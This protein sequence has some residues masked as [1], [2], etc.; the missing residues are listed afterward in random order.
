[1]L[2]HLTTFLG[3]TAKPDASE[4]AKPKGEG[5]DFAAV[6]EN[7]ADQMPDKKEKFVA[8]P[9]EAGAPENDAKDSPLSNTPVEPG[10]RKAALDKA[11]GRSDAVAA[12]DERVETGSFDDASDE[13]GLTAD[14]DAADTGQEFT[15]ATPSADRIAPRRK[16]SASDRN[17]SFETVE[18]G[19]AQR[20]KEAFMPL[21]GS[22]GP[23]V[24]NEHPAHAEILKAGDRRSIESDRNLTSAD[25][26]SMDVAG[27]GDRTR[28]VLPPE[29]A[30]DA[31]LKRTDFDSRGLERSTLDNRGTLASRDQENGI[32]QSGATADSLAKA[33]AQ[34]VGSG[35]TGSGRAD[36]GGAM[37]GRRADV[38]NG[39]VQTDAMMAARLA[40]AKGTRPT[41]NQTFVTTR[42]TELASASNTARPQDA[43][44]KVVRNGEPKFTTEPGPSDPYSWTRALAARRA[45]GG[46][47]AET[48]ARM[49]PAGSVDQKRARSSGVFASGTTNAIQTSIESRRDQM[50]PG[51]VGRG[52][53]GINR[54]V[55]S[56]MDASDVAQAQA[57]LS[58]G[59]PQ[60]KFGHSLL[61]THASSI[62]EAREGA[63]LSDQV[64][65][66]RGNA[67]ADSFAMSKL[68]RAENSIAID[69]R[70][71]GG[72]MEPGLRDQAAR[73]TQGSHSRGEIEMVPSGGQD[74]DP[75][76]S[77]F[78][79][80]RGDKSDWIGQPN[81]PSI[82]GE[83]N[84]KLDASVTTAARERNR[85]GFSAPNTNEN[86]T[87][88]PESRS[89][90]QAVL[91]SNLRNG[92]VGSPRASLATEA[93]VD[94]V[95][96]S[97]VAFDV[98]SKPNSQ[99]VGPGAA[100]ADTARHL[101]ASP[102][103]SVQ[104]FTQQP[105]FRNPAPGDASQQGGAP[106]IDETPIPNRFSAKAIASGQLSVNQNFERNQARGDV[107][108]QERTALTEE[109][110][111]SERATTEPV[112]PPRTMSVAAAPNVGPAETPRPSLFDQGRVRSQEEE[113][114]VSMMRAT[115]ELRTGT[116]LPLQT[117]S[118]SAQTPHAPTMVLR[119]IM[120]QIPRLSEGKIE[121]RLSPEELG[122]VRMHMTPG[123]QGMTVHIQADRPETLDLLRRNIDQLARDLAEAG[124]ETANFSFGEGTGQN[125]ANNGAE[126]RGREGPVGT[127]TDTAIP[128]AEIQQSLTASMDGL[129][130]RV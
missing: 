113:L 92:A 14:L 112:A 24:E 81:R 3:L 67:S 127:S 128:A 79:P 94:M 110:R 74:S 86:E 100:A 58:E 76:T 77:N 75:K 11:L 59:R 66:G 60:I 126:E 97:S 114:D 49:P 4:T 68:A 25:G 38:Q 65:S 36:E 34:T 96:R 84:S 22:D 53:G 91:Q 48:T 95:G 71:N 32:G 73:G 122:H 45:D 2:T 27:R 78:E 54:G 28:S 17:G 87:L 125:D 72:S 85:E 51:E 15:L 39:Q 109:R 107:L 99:A 33:G 35:A 61:S 13:Y 98:S 37:I 102:A 120:D 10:S 129:D 83:A 118:Q 12:G 88:R 101:A 50:L 21:P 116:T 23:L 105:P 1:M 90:P 57:A 111:G 20:E 69:V 30:A 62:G 130:I 117:G 29:I 42:A 26:T 43:G 70:M 63:Q 40:A 46:M 52:V 64:K 56:R 16:D 103:A 6:F 19:R 8:E 119:Q 121:V 5:A 44:D 41:Q 80:A 115:N 9:D 93:D 55:L 7:A 89:N 82:T 123:E 104:V 124:Y 108:R 106:S 47:M 18:P 31:A